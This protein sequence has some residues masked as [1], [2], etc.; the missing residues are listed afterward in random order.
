MRRNPSM[1]WI[2]GPLTSEEQPLS[3]RYLSIFLDERVPEPDDLLGVVDAE[4]TT[5]ALPTPEQ[6]RAEPDIAAALEAATGLEKLV[7]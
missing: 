1:R 7:V 4:E 2:S 3:R 5:S 6:L